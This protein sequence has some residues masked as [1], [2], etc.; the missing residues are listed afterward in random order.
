MIQ[1]RVRFKNNRKKN[2]TWQ[3]K[4]KKDNKVGK[5]KLKELKEL[6]MG[7]SVKNYCSRRK[8]R[9][10]WFERLEKKHKCIQRQDKV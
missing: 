10:G 5:I 8:R 1:R 6:Q 4:Q 3:N 7:Q 2:M 9:W